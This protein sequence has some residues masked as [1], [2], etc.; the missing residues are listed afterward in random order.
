MHKDIDNYNAKQCCMNLHSL[1]EK[2]AYTRK[3]ME[4]LTDS[5][6]TIRALQLMLAREEDEKKKGS[7]KRTYK[8]SSKI[9]Q[10]PAKEEHEVL[11]TLIRS[12]VDKGLLYK[13]RHKDIDEEEIRTICTKINGVIKDQYS[14]RDTQKAMYEAKYMI[15]TLWKRKENIEEQEE[16]LFEHDDDPF[17][18]NC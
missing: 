8:K 1:R 15:Q 9:M 2:K 12:E 10:I 18:L 17:G 4:I 6:V 7:T 13:I 14:S 5:Q 16:E 11:S 3:K